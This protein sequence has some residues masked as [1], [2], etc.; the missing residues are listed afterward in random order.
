MDSSMG[1]DYSAVVLRPGWTLGSSGEFWKHRCLPPTLRDDDVIGLGCSPEFRM[2]SD[3]CKS[4][5]SLLCSSFVS[6]ASLW[7]FSFSD[8]QDPI[9]CLA[10][11][12]PQGPA[13][14]SGNSIPAA[15]QATV[16]TQVSSALSLA[17]PLNS[18]AVISQSP[19]D[20]MHLPSVQSS[21]PIASSPTTDMLPQ[22]GTISTLSP[23]TDL[24][25]TLS[26]GKSSFP[27]P[28]TSA[29]V[30]VIMTSASPDKTGKYEELSCS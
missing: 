16:S 14:S 8:L 2:V 21:T 10:G 17:T 22:S 30:K 20:A 7:F 5:D 23:Q 25:Y 6:H 15:T 4:R 28:T 24:S 19:T 12:Y 27:T 1:P 11:G 9:L 3:G 26:P 13:V 18:P 29:L